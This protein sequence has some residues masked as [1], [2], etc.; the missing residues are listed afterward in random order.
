MQGEVGIRIHSK[1]LHGLEGHLVIHRKESETF[2]IELRYIYGQIGNH[3]SYLQDA[4]RNRLKRGR[5]L[6]AN[7]TDDH[8]KTVIRNELTG[9]CIDKVQC[10]S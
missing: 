6:E 8:P 2:W 10:I 7:M 4:L 9:H 5:T 3:L 1:C